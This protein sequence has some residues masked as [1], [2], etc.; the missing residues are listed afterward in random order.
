MIGLNKNSNK[1]IEAAFKYFIQSSFVTIIGFFAISI[2]YI[3]SGT[4]FINE[5]VILLQNKSPDDI[6]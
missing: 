6:S 4:L 3:L 1:G 5:L 2:I